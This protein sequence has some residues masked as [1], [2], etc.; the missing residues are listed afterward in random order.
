MDQDPAK[1][2]CKRK[3]A[4]EEN[5]MSKCNVHVSRDGDKEREHTK[6]REGMIV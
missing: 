4:E 6:K 3:S 2:A 1:D 5:E